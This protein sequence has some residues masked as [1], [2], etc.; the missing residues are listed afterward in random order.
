MPK[1]LSL[2]NKKALLVSIS[3]KRIFLLFHLFHKPENDS[4]RLRAIHPL[5]L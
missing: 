1:E 4:S 5:G 2:L 3:K